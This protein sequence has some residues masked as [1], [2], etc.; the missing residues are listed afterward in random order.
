MAKDE[1]K[2]SICDKIKAFDWSNVTVEPA[3]FLY[4]LGKGFAS[5]TDHAIL[6]RYVYTFIS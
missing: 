3:M 6:Y 5:P 4:A 1:Q 2:K